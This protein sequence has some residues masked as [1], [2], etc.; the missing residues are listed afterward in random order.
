MLCRTKKKKKPE[1]RCQKRQISNLDERHIARFSKG[2]TSSLANKIQKG[3]ELTVSVVT[4]HRRLVQNKLFT[5]SPRKVPLLTNK[6]SAKKLKYAQKI[7]NWL[8]EKW[9]NFCGRTKVKL[10]CLLELNPTLRYVQRLLN[11]L[12]EVQYTRKTVK[13]DGEKAMIWDCFSY[14]G[15]TPIQ[16]IKKIMDQKVWVE[17]LNSVMWNI[18]I[19]W[20]FQ[21]DDDSKNTS[22]LAKEWFCANVV[23]FMLWPA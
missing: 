21:H 9:R 6:N 1:A 22:K 17:I 13:H 16:E 15:V 4:I 18:A 8:K 10:F 12:N 11:T 5:R 20:V 7:F 2:D 14:T 23:E 19:T 3:L